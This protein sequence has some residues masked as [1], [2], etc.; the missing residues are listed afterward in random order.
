MCWLI[1]LLWFWILSVNIKVLLYCKHVFKPN[2][3]C[4]F[5]ES[6]HYSRLRPIVWLRELNR[7]Q[8]WSDA[9][10]VSVLCG[11]LITL[12]YD[13]HVALQ[14]V[15]TAAGCFVLLS[16]S[17]RWAQRDKRLEKSKLNLEL[18][19]LS[20]QDKF[21]RKE[22]HTWSM[23]RRTLTKVLSLTCSV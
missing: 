13:L 4:L 20:V 2:S 23:C 8:T 3:L 15:W 10:P 7:N 18:E 14:S 22:L 9:R 19:P 12:L 16:G 5:S 17:V 21:Q 6:S 1:A 11:L